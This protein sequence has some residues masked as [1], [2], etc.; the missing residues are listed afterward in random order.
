MTPVEIVSYRTLSTI[1][2][3][4]RIQLIINWRKKK[5]NYPINSIQERLH[6]HKPQNEQHEQ[7]EHLK[8]TAN[9][10]YEHKQQQNTTIQQMIQYDDENANLRLLM[11]VAVGLWEEKQRTLI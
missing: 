6:H 8:H 3:F 11:D 7:T 2:R 5:K 4:S 1:I 10:R 9:L